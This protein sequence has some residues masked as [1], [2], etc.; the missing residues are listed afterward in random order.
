[1]NSNGSLWWP[2]KKVEQFE[3][4]WYLRL[5]EHIVLLFPTDKIFPVSCFYFQGQYLA[6]RTELVLS[7]TTQVI[8]YS[9]VFAF[10]GLKFQIP[11]VIFSEVWFESVHFPF[12]SILHH[13][14][15]RVLGINIHSVQP[16]KLINLHKLF[17]TYSCICVNDGEKLPS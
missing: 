5:W 1:M 10:Y 13:L 14:H 2:K 15:L 11:F 12:C 6:C 16:V 4:H 3:S 17:Q 9:S 7:I 8:C